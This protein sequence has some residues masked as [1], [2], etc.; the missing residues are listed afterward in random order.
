MIKKEERPKVR[1]R[2]SAKYHA[3]GS[4]R[5]IDFERKNVE[6]Q[7]HGLDRRASWTCLVMGSANQNHARVF[8]AHQ[9]TCKEAERLIVD[10]NAHANI[11]RRAK[12]PED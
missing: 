12:L 2:N 1:Q 5:R 7:E 4:L 8:I 11:T 3:Q 6:L 10:V 9:I